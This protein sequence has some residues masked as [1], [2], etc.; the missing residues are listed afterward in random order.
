MYSYLVLSTMLL[1]T[2][3]EAPVCGTSEYFWRR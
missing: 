2:F 1:F 3:L